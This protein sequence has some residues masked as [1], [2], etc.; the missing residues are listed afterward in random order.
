MKPVI[1]NFSIFS[2]NQ[3]WKQ[4]YES[5]DR[6]IYIIVAS[7]FFVSIRKNNYIQEN[8]EY[9]IE[10]KHIILDAQGARPRREGLE[11]RKA[12]HHDVPLFLSRSRVLLYIYSLSFYI[13]LR[14][15]LCILQ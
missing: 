12:P 8:M 1:F 5:I 9:A 14:V 4:V 15:N 7:L 2:Q 6:V 3:V 10:S 11:H 13:V